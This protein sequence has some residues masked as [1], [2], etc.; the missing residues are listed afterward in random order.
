MKTSLVVVPLLCVLLISCASNNN[1]Q[2]PPP[3]ETFTISGTV[4]GLAANAA[5][6]LQNNGADN[7]SVTLNGSFHFSSTIKSGSAYNVTVLTQPSNPVQQCAVTNGVGTAMADVSNVTVTCTTPVPTYTISGTLSG[8]ATNSTGLVLQ[9][10]GGD[11]LIVKANG[12][13]H[14]ATAVKSGSG[15]NVTILTQPSSPVQQCT[16]A[17]PVGT[18]TANVTNVTVTCANPAT[19]AIGGTVANLAT[20]NGGLVLQNNAG[21][22]LSITSNGSF[23]FA[24]EIASGGAYNVTVF[25]QPSSPTQQCTITNGVGTATNTVSNITVECGHGEWAWMAGSQS[26]NVISTYGTLG[27]AAA[28]NTPGGRQSPATWT[29]S[30]GDFWLFGGYGKDSNGNLLP[31]N[32]LWKFSGGEW[33]WE[34]GSNVGGQKGN[35]GTLGVSSTNTVPGAR[36][37]AAAWTDSSGD[38]WLFGGNGFDSGGT[39]ADLNDLWKYSNGEWTWMG[40]SDLV[41]SKGQYGTLGVAGAANAP[42]ARDWAATWTDASGNFWLFGGTGYDS[43]SAIVGQLSDLWKYS[44]GE[45]TW[46]SGPKVINQKGIYGTKGVANAANIP[47][48]RFAAFSWTDS[49]GNLWLF[50]GNADD[51]NGT[52]GYMNDLWEYSAGEWTWVGGSNVVYQQG[53]YGT[54]GTAATSN[55]P[56]SRLAGTV[57][58]D[59]QGNAWIFGGGGRDSVGSYGALNDLWKYSNGEW[60]WMSGSNEVGATSTFGTEGVLYPGNVPGN[61]STCSAWKDADGNLWLFGGVT[62]NSVAENLNDLWMY[63][64]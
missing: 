27:V 7:L 52:P 22:N 30:S 58:T 15:Y 29:D 11:N 54:Q 63:M 18:A 28:A 41:N 25:I 42:G 19:F 35:Y 36:S 38:L 45:W 40:G 33:T 20:N 44:N 16:V 26:Y 51:S 53:V 46:M 60:T 61:R 34:G 2:T 13:F 57:W 55:V 32:D 37:E 8:L 3:P 24:T 14:F 50:G 64:P 48:G 31:M 23:Q 9:D 10:N 5:L 39:E 4:T 21:D 49:T 59:A 47:G 1:S 43:S 62:V 17:N 6:V 56:G 12:A